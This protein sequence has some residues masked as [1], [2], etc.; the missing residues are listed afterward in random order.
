MGA[1]AL[2]ATIST[3]QFGLNPN[4][5]RYRTLTSGTQSTVTQPKIVSLGEQT[6]LENYWRRN[7]GTGGIMPRLI[8]WGKDRV[9]IIHLGQRRTGGYGVRIQSMTKALDGIADVTAIEE[10]P[11]RGQLTTQSLTS[12]FLVL[13]VDRAIPDFRLR[14]TKGF[15]GGVGNVPTGSTVVGTPSGYRIIA[16]PLRNGWGSYCVGF[17]CN[18]AGSGCS[19]IGDL[20]GFYGWSNQ[21]FGRPNYIDCQLNWNDECVAAL[22]IGAVQGNYAINVTN[23]RF[24]Q[25]TAVIQY[26]LVQALYGTGGQQTTRPYALVRLNRS[27]SKVRAERVY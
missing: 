20:N 16:P 8:E 27:V 4:M 11:A 18:Y 24:E 13:A 10:E 6:D 19:L 9:V 26:S 23:V 22:H 25:G 7:I 12:P 17:D 15:L 3:A 5:V 21:C 14:W 2:I 1:V